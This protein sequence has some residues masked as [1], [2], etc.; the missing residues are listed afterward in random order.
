MTPRSHAVMSVALAGLLFGPPRQEAVEVTGRVTVLERGNR[1]AKD[2]GEAVVWLESR[3]DTALEID[4]VEVLTERKQFRP[5]VTVITAGSTISFPNKDPFNHNVFS[6]SEKASFDLGLYPRE[7]AVVYVQSARDRA[8]VLQRP[9]EDVRVRARA[10]QS[11]FHPP[12]RGRHVQD[13]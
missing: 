9:R 5:Q 6:L 4:T 8:G 2:V 12:G 13:V 11:A 1:S 3:P 10:G 7:V